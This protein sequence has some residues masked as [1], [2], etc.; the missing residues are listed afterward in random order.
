MIKRRVYSN[1]SLKLINANKRK[2][3]MKNF[4]TILVTSLMAG[5]FGSANASNLETQAEQQMVI[6]VQTVIEKLKEKNGRIENFTAIDSLVD[7]HTSRVFDIKTNNLR[8]TSLKSVIKHID[9][10]YLYGSK[11]EHTEVKSYPKYSALK[12]YYIFNATFTNGDK[13]VYTVVPKKDTA[14]QNI[15]KATIERIFMLEGVVPSFEK[16]DREKQT[17]QKMDTVNIVNGF[18][19]IDFT[20]NN[21]NYRVVFKEIEGEEDNTLFAMIKKK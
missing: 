20:S 16:I 1:M 18:E 3:V 12:N 14:N 13:L 19:L 4:K 21:K 2:T 15:N 6:P 8:V 5:I 9:K 17:I 10:T 11:I 7:T